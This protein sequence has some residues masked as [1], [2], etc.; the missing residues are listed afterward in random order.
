MTIET[1]KGTCSHCK[2]TIHALNFNVFYRDNNVSVIYKS[3]KFQVYL[4]LDCKAKLASFII[5]DKK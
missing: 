2:K 1:Y 3:H 5:R 4:C